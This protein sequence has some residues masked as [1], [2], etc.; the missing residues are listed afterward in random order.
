MPPRHL[1]SIVAWEGCDRR[2][3]LIGNNRASEPSLRLQ[4]SSAGREP[5]LPAGAPDMVVCCPGRSRSGDVRPRP[6]TPPTRG[7][8][9]QV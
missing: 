9:I 7:L 4:M 3:Y 6:L 2:R 8:S 1:T 5:T